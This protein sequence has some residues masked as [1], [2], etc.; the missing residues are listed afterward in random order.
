MLW[1][2]KIQQTPVHLCPTNPKGCSTT[3][4]GHPC[5]VTCPQPAQE[6][7]L[8]KETTTNPWFGC[9]EA[10]MRDQEGS[11]PSPAPPTP[12]MGPS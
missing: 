2:Q 12:L 1:R 5:S 9:G 7:D 6:K 11:A 4:C 8:H 3:A 10:Q